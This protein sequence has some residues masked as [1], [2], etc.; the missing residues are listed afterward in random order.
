MPWV[1]PTESRPL[2]QEEMEQNAVMCWSY[3]QSSGWTLEAVAG[4]LGNAQAESTI[5][6]TRWQSDIPG[7][8][9][10]GG[11]GILQWTPW[12][13]LI[14]YSNAIAGNWQTGAT[15]VRVVDYEL[16]NGYGYYPTINYPLSANDYRKST[17]T[18][19]YLAY[20]WLYNFERPADLNQPIR[21]T[22]AREWY[23]YLSGVT[24]PVPPTPTSKKRKPD[25]PW[26]LFMR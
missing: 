21:Q 12:T 9:G 19:E 5:N 1:E 4:L 17:Q 20:A 24:P 16:N 23:N 10:G 2:T 14:E 15:Q 26:F 13:I 7:E 25:F 18:P 3:F 8:A 6:P 22:Y 11:Y